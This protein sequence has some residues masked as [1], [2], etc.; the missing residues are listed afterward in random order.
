MAT[1]SY[2]LALIDALNACGGKRLLTM[3]D[4]RKLTG[5]VDSRTLR[6]KFPFG[7]DAT[8]SVYQYAEIMA[9]KE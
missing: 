6:R 1:K 5:L 2:E 4:V 7:R 8:L 9:G 3:S